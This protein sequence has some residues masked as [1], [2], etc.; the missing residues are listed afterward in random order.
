MEEKP[1]P[2]KGVPAHL[3]MFDAFWA[4]HLKILAKTFIGV[5]LWQ[6]KSIVIGAEQQLI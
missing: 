5:K 1:L 4:L 3:L 2:R 6:S